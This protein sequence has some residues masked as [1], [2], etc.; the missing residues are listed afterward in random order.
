VLANQPDIDVLLD[1]LP[2]QDIWGIGDKKAKFLKGH[3]I[4]TAKAFRDAPSWWVRQHLSVVSA[5]TQ[6]EL[7]GVQAF[8]IIQE[9]ATEQEIMVNRALGRPVTDYRSLVEALS[10]YAT[11][12]CEKLRAEHLNVAK[13]SVYLAT[14]P[15]RKREPQYSKSISITLPQPTSYTPT[16]ID[17][18]LEGLERIYKPFP[19]HR[20]G[21][22]LRDLTFETP[23][24]GTLF[25]PHYLSER[26]KRLMQTMDAI[27]QKFGREAIRFLGSGMVRPWASKQDNRS[28]RALTQWKEI[29]IVKVR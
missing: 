12:A 8:P 19:F 15:F 6:L 25:A 9:R 22:S 16:I 17:A 23:E 20:V 4:L 14:N 10:L 26:E 2:I 11:R 13:L 28:N 18:A 21:I 5:R 27:C 3:N 7:R 24:Q 29:P 1:T